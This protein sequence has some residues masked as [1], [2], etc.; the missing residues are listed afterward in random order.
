MKRKA[1]VF[2][3]SGLTGKALLTQLSNTSAYDEI[4]SFVRKPTG[5]VLPKVE[6]VVIDFD[7]PD[8]FK[9]QVEGTDL[10]ICLGTTLAK[11]GS[12]KAFYKVDYTYI[13]T[14]AQIAADNHVKNLCLISAVGSNK[15]S[16]IYYSKVKG[17]TEEAVAAMPFTSIHILRPALLLGDRKE[18]RIMERLAVRI[19][20]RWPWLYG[21]PFAAYRP[22]ADVTV[23]NAMIRLA[24]SDKKGKHIYESAAL[25]QLGAE[26]PS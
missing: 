21:G 14:S 23:A 22:I 19:S 2:G 6:E 26:Q 17:L 5:N 18:K 13:V 11:A 10:Y 20:E 4:V 16:L 1:L 8:S 12:P 3:G 9:N 7:K 25:H 24:L 15:N